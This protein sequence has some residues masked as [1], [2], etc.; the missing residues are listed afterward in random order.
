M[1]K[2]FNLLLEL[3][4]NMIN[5]S[6]FRTTQS[7]WY[8]FSNGSECKVDRLI[9]TNYDNIK[10]QV[11]TH[12]NEG[13]YALDVVYNWRDAFCIDSKCYEYE[14][15]RRK[16]DILYME[17]IDNDKSSTDHLT[18]KLF[19]PIVGSFMVFPIPKLMWIN[20]KSFSYDRKVERYLSYYIDV[21]II[22]N[23]LVY[24]IYALLDVHPIF[25][26]FTCFD[27]Y[28]I[29]MYIRREYEVKTT[30]VIYTTFNEICGKATQGIG[31]LTGYYPLIQCTHKEICCYTP[32]A[33]TFIKYI[34]VK[35]RDGIITF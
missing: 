22:R 35:G 14:R 30:F 7:K 33:F 13:G 23:Q 18:N 16:L 26:N 29:D 31:T 8:T 21:S 9:D 15:F 12:H 28:F 20:G 34:H 17:V 24:N 4:P 6:E 5:L 32:R 10:K 3:T 19:Y 1:V 11:V 25:Q 27:M 2:G